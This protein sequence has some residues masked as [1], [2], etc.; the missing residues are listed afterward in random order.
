MA[1]EKTNSTPLRSAMKKPSTSGGTE[2]KDKP[3]TVVKSTR[4]SGAN[5]R[6]A[7]QS[8]ERTDGGKK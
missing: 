8:P 2:N 5:K 7:S 1:L 6:K 4:I 3:A